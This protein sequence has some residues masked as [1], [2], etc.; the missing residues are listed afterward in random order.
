MNDTD[1]RQLRQRKI[2]SN[3]SRDRSIVVI[4]SNTYLSEIDEQYIISEIII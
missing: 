3:I 2:S 1:L 4:A